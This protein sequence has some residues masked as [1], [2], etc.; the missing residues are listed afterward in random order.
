MLS[1]RQAPDDERLL[2]GKLN[3]F[4]LWHAYRAAFQ[5]LTFVTLVWAL[6]AVCQ[7]GIN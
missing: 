6:V 3:A 5:F 7:Q 4:A 2:A 1:L